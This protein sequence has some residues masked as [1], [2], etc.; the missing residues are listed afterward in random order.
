MGEAGRLAGSPSTPEDRWSSSAEDFAVAGWGGQLNTSYRPEDLESSI[1]HLIDPGAA[2]ETVHWGRNYLYRTSLQCKIGRVSVVVKQFRNAGWVAKLR[3]RRGGSKALR[4][5]R[6]AWAFEA[7]GL[8]TAEPVMLVE[9]ESLEGPSFFVSRHLEGMVEARYLLRAANRSRERRE[10]PEVDF[11]TFLASCGRVL[12]KMHDCGFFHRDLSIGNVLVRMDRG[13]RQAVLPEDLCIIDLNR[14]RKQTRVSTVNRTRDLCRLSI[15]RPEDQ[16]QFLE[17]YWDHET[18]PF[19]RLLYR[20]Y[21]HGFLFKIESKKWIRSKTRRLR[22]WLRPRR[23]HVHIPAIDPEATAREKIVWDHLSDQ[24][25]QHA[26]RLEK[27]AVRLRDAPSHLRQNAAFLAA[28]PKIWSRYR[29][30]KTSLYT[31]P[32]LIDGLGICVRPEPGSPEELLDAVEDLGVKKVLLRLHPWEEEHTHEE[33]LARELSSRGYDL[34]FALP[35]NRDLVRDPERWRA[36]IEELA[37]RFVPYGRNFQVGQAINR[38]KWGV[39]RYSEYIE[40]ATSASAIL[41]R[42][43]GVRVLGPAVI[44][45]ELQA[46]ASVLNLDE[47]LYFDAVA[48]LLY[49][50]RRGAPENTQLGFDT[51]DKIVLLKAIAESSRN[52][53][54]ESW[55]TEVNWPLR[56]GPHSPAGKSVS[57][58]ESTQADYLSRYYLLGLCTGAVERIYW[59]QLVARGYGLMSR[60]EDAGRLC[61][62]P[63]FSALATLAREVEGSHFIERL[64]APVGCFLY[65]FEKGNGDVVV[66]GWCKGK[67]ARVKLPRIPSALVK[68]DGEVFAL[69]STPEV[70][71]EPSVRFFRF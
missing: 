8:R 9:A 64:S 17:A 54:P 11:P 19:R 34:A 70:E 42:Y 71:I 30:L 37:E 32:V 52:S 27:L 26:G 16:N 28:V 20:I 14:T 47:D 3:R 68:R 56:E 18:T 53:G 43:P 21:H 45:F 4:S 15:F 33:E 61:R 40:L 36:K 12:R 7:A 25:H 38:S 69:E 41:R 6:V 22:E 48:S 1:H 29:Q 51:V 67:S 60:R 50:D 24:P 10:F 46:T 55:I 58:E 31:K 66:A 59:W 35:Q 39:W 49:V 23:A 2:D 44:D 5:W 57:V 65:L 62:R 13:G 63:A